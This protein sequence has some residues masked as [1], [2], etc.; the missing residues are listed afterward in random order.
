L[1]VS[2]GRAAAAGQSLVE[3]ALILPIMLLLLLAVAD[4][5][6][7][8]T[9]MTAIESAAREA[10]DYGGFDSTYWTEPGATLAEI[11][12]RACVASSHLPDYVGPDDNCTNPTVVA[13]RV[14]DTPS[15]EI[16]DQRDC[17]RRTD[18][19]W[20]EVTLRHRFGL[21]FP[22]NLQVFDLHIGFPSELVFERTS[23]FAMGDLTFESQSP[24][25][26]TPGP[27]TEPTD[28]PTESPSASA[29]EEASPPP[30]SASTEPSIPPPASVEPTVSPSPSVEPTVSPSVE[31]TVSPAPS[32]SVSPSAEAVP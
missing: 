19:C 26:G 13:I 12:R 5:A 11:E 6:R 15:T 20:V 27:G 14:L 3:F 25:P 2:R 1:V 28:A 30:A 17:V 22:M 10:A 21:L 29:S 7:I 8:Y 18:P 32:P 23:T 9:T 31:P 24:P 4:L 16:A